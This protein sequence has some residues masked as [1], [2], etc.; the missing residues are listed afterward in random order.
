ML[1]VLEISTP[2]SAN[3]TEGFRAAGFGLKVLGVKKQKALKM[4]EKPQ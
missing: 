1:G 3:L 2:K 4:S